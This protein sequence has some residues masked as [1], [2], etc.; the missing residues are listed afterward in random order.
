MEL[1]PTGKVKDEDE[2]SGGATTC[3]LFQTQS[4]Y[5]ITAGNVFIVWFISWA[6]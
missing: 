5:G 1:I 2:D 6:S 3:F 4:K